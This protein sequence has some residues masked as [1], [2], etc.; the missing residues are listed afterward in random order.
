MI[1]ATSSSRISEV[2]HNISCPAN[3]CSN[4]LSAGTLVPVSIGNTTAGRNFDLALRA[5]VIVTQPQNQF[6]PLGQAATLDVVVTGELPLTY[7]WYRGSS[8]TTTDPVVGATATSYTTPALTVNASYWVRVSNALG[9]ADSLAATLTVG[10]PPVITEQPEGQ[11]IASGQSATFSVTASGTPPLAYQWY[12]G[13]TG[14]MTAPIA[15]ATSSAFTTPA[16]TTAANYWVRVSNPFGVANS[17]TA[18]VTIGVA[19]TIT[20]QPASPTIPPGQTVGLTVTASGTPPL[21]YQWYLGTS[22]DTTAPIAGATSSAFTTPALTSAANY[23]VR[24]SNPFGVA[25][26][27][28]AVITIG[29]APTITSHPQGRNVPEGESTTLS[30]V[31]TGTA[32]LGYQWYEGDSGVI[33]TPVP[34][35]TAATFTTPP[36]TTVQP[37]WVRV[38]SPYGLAD[39]VAATLTPVPVVPEP[40][41]LYVK[42]MVGN[43]VTLAWT[44]GFGQQPVTNHLI[45]G[46]ILGRTEVLAQLPTGSPGGTFTFIAPTGAFFVRVRAASG[47]TLGRP[48]DDMP[49]CVNAVCPAL[50]PVNLLGM[51][52]GSDIALAW[53]NPLE[54]GV[55]ARITLHVSG[56]LTAG[57]DLPGTAES[58]TYRGVPDGT[59]D[60]RLVA[61]TVAGCS[62]PSEPITLS[63]PETCSGRPNAPAKFMASKSGHTITV[64]WE[65]PEDGPA[66]TSYRL[67]VT[68]SFVGTLLTTG[69]RLSGTVGPGS[70]DISVAGTN[71]CG[72]GD[73]SPCR[74]LSRFRRSLQVRCDVNVPAGMSPT[75][76]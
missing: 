29:I 42:A 47:T 68:G 60:L 23:W 59:Y 70:Y 22:G 72:T 20:G 52:N 69:R 76:Q 1:V 24:V 75:F 36:V 26:S 71:A 7:Q 66:P 19:P 46:G 57:F 62:A 27:T 44:P 58:F 17:L 13:T 55:P 45:E 49:L 41:D 28:T 56:S 14:D 53:R 4:V 65:L 21:G 6:V 39:S 64:D 67:D 50:T 38:S 5:P 31:A 37:Y 35:A 25:N 10:T 34:G 40:T 54:S 18:A 73:G 9:S 74:S 12:L 61:C 30:V 16:L 51:V 2:Y 15:G 8:G 32:P 48:S 3:D 33:N 11:T 63:F 43:T